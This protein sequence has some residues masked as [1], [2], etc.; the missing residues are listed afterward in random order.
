MKSLSETFYQETENEGTYQS[1]HIPIH[2]EAG[3]G[4]RMVRQS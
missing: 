4:S 3:H 1:L 2:M